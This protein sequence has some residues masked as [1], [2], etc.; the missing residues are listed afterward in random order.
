MLEA[1]SVTKT[2][3]LIAACVGVL[4][5][6]ASGRIWGPYFNHDESESYGDFGAHSGVTR[7]FSR[8]SEGIGL[9]RSMSGR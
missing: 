3:A 2:L 8:V 9:S 1:K 7:I 6:E 4:S 5:A